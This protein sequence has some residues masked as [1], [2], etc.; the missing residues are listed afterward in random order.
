MLSEQDI[1][2]LDLAVD[3]K[4]ARP[5]PAR[6]ALAIQRQIG[7]SVTTVAKL[8]TRTTTNKLNDEFS[9]VFQ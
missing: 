2:G 6:P 5:A 7:A 1:I 4:N 3:R 9:L 8:V